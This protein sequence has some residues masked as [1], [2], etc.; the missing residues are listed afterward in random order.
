MLVNLSKRLQTT[1]SAKI[2]RGG[3]STPPVLPCVCRKADV[4]DFLV[5]SR[6]YM[7]MLI[8]KY[9][10]AEGLIGVTAI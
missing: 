6:P 8:S 1:E 10:V 9:S 2:K 7:I 5:A 3:P 4:H